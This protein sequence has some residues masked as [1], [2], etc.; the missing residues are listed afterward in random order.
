MHVYWLSICKVCASKGSAYGRCDVQVELTYADDEQLQL[1]F[2]RFY[3]AATDAEAAQFATNVRAKA[4]TRL[5]M[6]QV[7]EHFVQHRTSSMEEAMADIRL[8]EHN[9]GAREY[10]NRQSFYA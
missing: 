9:E 6:S 1:S 10:D 5:T 3:K 8:G 7:Q 4:G 2:K